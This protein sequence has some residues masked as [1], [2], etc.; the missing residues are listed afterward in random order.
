VT[1]SNIEIL[2][3]EG[4]PEVKP[5][6]ELSSLLGP[7]LR[8][9]ARP[10]DILVVTHKIVSK[11]EGAVVDLS[12]V[13]PSQW[14][15]HWASKWGKDARQIE[16]VLR[17]SAA[18]L[19]M[20]YGIIISRTLHGLVCANAGVDRSNSP[21]ETVC[22]LPEDP[23]ASARKLCEQLSS[24]LGFHLPVL[25]SDS[26][27]RAWRIGIVNVAVGVAGMSPFRDYRG[28]N[29]PHGYPLEAS[30]MASADML[31]SAA[32]LAMGKVDGVPAA[33]VRGFEWT[34][35]PGQASSMIRPLEQD[36]F[37]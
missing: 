16:V 7:L 30:I 27:G 25:I 3:V 29:D 37:R 26:F 34:P 8:E 12:T 6:Q 23:D 18:I 19:R 9:N 32:E 15:Q 33:L 17:Q 5:G 24:E 2:R 22:L 21:G 35:G 10:G 36:F 13:E 4:L 1:G 14:A 31:C 20:E 28:Q 11:A